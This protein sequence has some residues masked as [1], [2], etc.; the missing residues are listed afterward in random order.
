MYKVKSTIFPTSYPISTP[1]PRDNYVNNL[2]HFPPDFLFIIHTYIVCT[3]ACV[4]ICLC[5]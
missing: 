1:A 4:S 2:S 3:R 5:A